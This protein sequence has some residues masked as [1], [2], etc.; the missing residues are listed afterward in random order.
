[1][2]DSKWIGDTKHAAAYAGRALAGTGILVIG[3]M[4]ALDV[5]EFSGRLEFD[6]AS[7]T[8]A[9]ADIAEIKIRSRHFVRGGAGRHQRCKTLRRE[10][11]K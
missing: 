1:M 9:G 4:G 5:S 3:D 2:S 8:A 6:A 10:E 11:E 7:Q